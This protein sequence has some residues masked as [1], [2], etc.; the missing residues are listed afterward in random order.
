MTKAYEYK[1]CDGEK[2]DVEKEVFMMSERGWI[3][4]GSLIVTSH[5]TSAQSMTDTGRVVVWYAQAMTRG[6]EQP[7]AWS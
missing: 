1:I 7:G 3:T 4:H 5:K 2:A 6:Y